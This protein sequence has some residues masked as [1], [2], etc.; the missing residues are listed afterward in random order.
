[1]AGRGR[2]GRKSSSSTSMASLDGSTQ[3][4]QG[5]RFAGDPASAAAAV[6]A[7]VELQLGAG[8]S[9]T[10]AGNA[11]GPF[12]V[13]PAASGPASSLMLGM[14]MHSLQLGGGGGGLGAGA[15]AGLQNGELD[16]AA[17]H[18]LDE[19]GAHAH[20]QLSASLPMSSMLDHSAVGADG[21]G[22][23]DDLLLN[24]PS[25]GLQ[26]TPNSAGRTTAPMRSMSM[27]GVAPGSA[28]PVVQATVL[29]DEQKRRPSS[30]VPSTPLRSQMR[31][32]LQQQ[33]AMLG[34]RSRSSTLLAQPL[35]SAVKQEP[36]SEHEPFGN[37]H[38]ASGGLDSQMDIAME[39][40]QESGQ[41]SLA[42]SS[43]T[44][45][46]SAGQPPNLASAALGVFAPSSF[47]GVQP[48][49]AFPEAVTVPRQVLNVRSSL[50]F[51]TAYHL[52][53]KQR[54]QLQ[55]FIST[56]MNQPGDAGM[57]L[58]PGLVGA[59]FGTA[60]SSTAASSVIG[61]EV[62]YDFDDGQD[63]AMSSLESSMISQSGVPSGSGMFNF[64]AGM[65]GSAPSD[66]DP[67]DIQTLIKSRKKKDNHNA[68]ERRRRY[69]IN[70][71]IVELGSLLPNAEIDP[72]ASKG[73]ILKRSVDYIK[74][75]Q[76]INRSLSEKLAQTGTVV[77]LPE[78]T[79][80]G[81]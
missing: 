31:L 33:Q 80:T 48:A 23:V 35:P 47:N 1:M 5:F 54:L 60:V 50:A 75:L 69:N 28:G 8:L 62:S 13:P 42:D 29:R 24:F 15:A 71:R 44:S 14:N 81:E 77:E 68:I 20:Q 64:G 56:T 19:F 53:E 65:A 38:D 49:G 27:L 70:D 22:S 21:L 40:Q 3:Q 34:S 61:E 57:S 9:N 55:E 7:A 58:P 78:F 16:A 18:G 52:H 25:I 30:S 45:S 46:I 59:E 51:P 67:D 39:D 76:D 79:S 6:A 32:Q 2:G 63:E 66:Y 36:L 73:S 43:R 4:Q 17:L 74:Y 37:E 10:A 26:L 41:S 11:R 12:M 72:K